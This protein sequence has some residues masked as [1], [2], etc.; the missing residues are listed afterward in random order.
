[1]C[2]LIDRIN[3]FISQSNS[4]LEWMWDQMQKFP[5]KVSYVFSAGKFSGLEPLSLICFCISCSHG[6]GQ[7]SALRAPIFYNQEDA[8]H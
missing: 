5:F 8:K 2:Q 4:T 6:S 7:C 3:R 1:M